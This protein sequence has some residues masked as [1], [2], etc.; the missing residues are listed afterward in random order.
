M[1]QDITKADFLSK[2]FN[3]E[4]HKEWVFSGDKPAVVDFWAEWCGP[5]R[6]LAPT[7]SELS[8][9]YA[10]KVDFFKVNTEQEQELA[11][12][13]GIRSIPSLLFIPKEGKPMMVPGALPKENLIE[14]IEKELLAPIK[15]E[16][17]EISA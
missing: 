14:V 1:A 13:F 4:Q 6:A 16:A 8:D 3:Y 12:V 11:A 17:N 2:V 10:G 7:I 9:E 5:C 15:S